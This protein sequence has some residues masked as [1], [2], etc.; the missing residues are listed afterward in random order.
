MV[1]QGRLSRCEYVRDNYPANRAG[2]SHFRLLDV[3]AGQA[4]P[5]FARGRHLGCAFV[6]GG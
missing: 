4:T 1:F 2:A 5:A 3:A 6:E